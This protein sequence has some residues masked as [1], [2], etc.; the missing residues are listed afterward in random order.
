M[1]QELLVAFSGDLQTVRG[2]GAKAGCICTGEGTAGSIWVP[3]DQ[4]VCVF[5]PR[6]VGQHL[7]QTTRRGRAQVSS[8]HRR[9]GEGEHDDEGGAGKRDTGCDMHEEDAG[10]LEMR[11]EEGMRRARRIMRVGWD[12]SLAWLVLSLTMFSSLSTTSPWQLPK[13]APAGACSRSGMYW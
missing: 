7:A 4:A 1:V 8:L 10:G 9:R 12:L 11:L 5:T 3:L 2:A 13:T 6:L